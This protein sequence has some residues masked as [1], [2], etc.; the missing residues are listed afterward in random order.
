VVF[1]SFKRKEINYNC[2]GKGP[3]G[4]KE[5]KKKKKCKER[6]SGHIYRREKT[7]GAGFANV[8]MSTDDLN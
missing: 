4:E 3:G 1:R 7:N 8:D 2:G 5:K 6:R